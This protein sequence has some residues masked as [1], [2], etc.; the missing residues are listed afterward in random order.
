MARSQ[1]ADAFIAL[2][3]D[4]PVAYHPR[5]A[6]VLGG[7]K[8]A[9]FISQLLYWD[10]KGSRPD[11]FIWKTQKEFENET[12][13]TRYE[14]ETARK[15]LKASG[16]LEE[17]KHGIPAK[18]HY[19]LNFK[20]L[21]EAFEKYQQTSMQKPR[22]QGCGNPANSDVETPQCITESTHESTTEKEVASENVPDEEFP[23]D[24]NVPP[25]GEK[26]SPKKEKPIRSFTDP[27]SMAAEVKRRRG[28]I[29]DWAVLG[30]EGI[31]PFY[32]ILLLFCKITRQDAPA[33]NESDV[34]KKWLRDLAKLA[35]TNHLSLGEFKKVL[36][37]LERDKSSDFYLKNNIW[38]APMKGGFPDALANFLRRQRLG[39]SRI[40]INTS[41]WNPS[42]AY[43]PGR[44]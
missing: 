27:L 20:K 14:Q 41:T 10:E 33:E 43:Q 9:V 38:K 11:G 13:L 39:P 44:R 22:I 42:G 2:L 32:E 1:R 8:Q 30:A 18:L 5:L 12:G 26:T 19:R 6:K 4:R 15:H 21:L 34:G 3:K 35:R 36:P 25:V 29:P 7:V 16:V 23:T 31:D 24:S 40:D 17:K 37:E 28:D